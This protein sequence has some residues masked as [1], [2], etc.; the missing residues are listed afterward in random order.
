MWVAVLNFRFVMEQALHIREF[1][2]E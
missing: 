1:S 2:G